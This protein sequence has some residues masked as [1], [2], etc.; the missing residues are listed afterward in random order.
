MTKAE[1]DYTAGR[2]EGMNEAAVGLIGALYVAMDE[3]RLDPEL[4]LLVSIKDYS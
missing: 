1:Q 3:I 2:D 4:S